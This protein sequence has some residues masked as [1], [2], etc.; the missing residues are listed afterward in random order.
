MKTRAAQRFSAAPTSVPAARRFATE[1]LDGTPSDVVQD[2]VLMV[3]ELATNCVRHSGTPFALAV[4]RSEEGI[5]V[6]VTDLAD[7]VPKLRSTRP[8]DSTGRGL[9]I[10][11][12][13]AQ[14][15]GVQAQAP[16]GKMV[17]FTV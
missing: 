15:W 1:A 7:G 8:S 16:A 14:Q 17:W 5:R 9:H 6:E 4:T 2:V 12:M 3:S 11:D 10:I 13:L